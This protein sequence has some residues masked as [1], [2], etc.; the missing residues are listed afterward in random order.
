MTHG[1]SDPVLFHTEEIVVFVEIHLA[2]VGLFDQA[3]VDL[4]LD[5]HHEAQH[6]VVGPAGE[7]DLA[8]VQLIQGAA[9]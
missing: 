3:V 1:S 4:A 2:K 7:E 6:V 5:L 9:D 8:R